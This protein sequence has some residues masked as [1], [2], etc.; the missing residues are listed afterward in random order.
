MALAS[1]LSCEVVDSANLYLKGL[2]AND[3]LCEK[4]NKIAN[5]ISKTMKLDG[6]RKGKI[7]LNVINA[8][9]GDKI[10]K[11]AEQEALSGAIENT[12]RENNVELN[13]ILGS[14]TIKKYDRNDLGIDVEV[15]IGV[16]PTIVLDNYLELIPPVNLNP[17]TDND[18]DNRLSDI[19]K[20]N[21]P[22]LEVDRSLNTGD[23]ANVDFEGFID[24]K[25]FEGGKSEGFDLEIGLKRFIDGFEDQLI[26][27]T[28]GS[29]RDVNVVFPE[30]YHVKDL[31]GKKALF[32]VKLNKIQER[33]VA[34]IDD[35]FIKSMLPND[36]QATLEKLKE[37]IKIQLQNENK[38]KLFNELK[39]PLVDSL[40][41]GTSFDLP[42]NIIEQ[43]L[44]I[45]FR[46]KLGS[47]DKDSLKEL[48]EDK[49][50]AEG[51]RENL[52]EDAIKSVKL[53]L[54][55]DFLAKK[56]NL[57]VSDDEVYQMLYYD[58]LMTNKNPKELID[59]YKQNNM[60]PA[61]K[62][63]L[64]EGKVLNNLLESRLNS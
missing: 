63:S 31:A 4:Q 3:Y 5:D 44:D 49:I 52:R 60:M 40:L 57:S 21:G 35:N 22:L 50:K 9:F 1:M 39:Q 13:K 25:A 24:D 41:A 12:M 11:D 43:E 47:I 26:G 56:L 45:L 64:L 17:I 10:K 62:I 51:M 54:I 18:I 55:I 7:P 61:L 38:N 42:N 32:K 20:A 27:M 33:G 29:E 30:N 8:R 28:K 53:T 6:F 58:A 16:L 36:D 14:P 15:Q 19:I 2:I 37:N 34:S 48:Q 23:I 46:N 59:F